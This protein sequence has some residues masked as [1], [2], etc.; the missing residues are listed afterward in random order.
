MEENLSALTAVE[1]GELADAF[2][3]TALEI[4]ILESVHG[5]RIRGGSAG[6]RVKRVF[7]ASV[8]ELRR[9]GTLNAM[10]VACT[11]RDGRADGPCAN[12]E[13]P[14]RDGSGGK[15]L[16]RGRRVS[17]TEKRLR[18]LRRTEEQIDLATEKCTVSTRTQCRNV[19]YFQFLSGG[20][21][22]AV[23]TQIIYLYFKLYFIR[24]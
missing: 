21:G 18:T 14:P 19:T 2:E 24:V 20:R 11:D 16:P 15:G 13:R 23:I 22:L 5:L 3:K 7:R 17:V 10:V 9:A 4:A 6:D 12:A 1:A 8:D